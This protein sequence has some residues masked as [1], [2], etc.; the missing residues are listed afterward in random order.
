MAPF[1]WFSS[2]ASQLLALTL[3]HFLWQG[4]LVAGGAA[5][6]ASCFSHRRADLRHAIYLVC[7]VVMTA[8]PVVTF[9]VL[10]GE[11]AR[12]DVASELTVASVDFSLRPTL[13]RG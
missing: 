11:L 5:L 6:L 4:L 2:P 12:S 10:E 8:C 7:F 3:L 9:L 1:D 13:Q